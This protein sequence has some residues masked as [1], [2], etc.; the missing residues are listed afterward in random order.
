MIPFDEYSFSIVPVNDETKRISRMRLIP[1]NGS[2]TVEYVST[3]TSVFVTPQVGALKIIRDVI[4][5]IDENEQRLTIPEEVVYEIN[6]FNYLDYQHRDGVLVTVPEVDETGQHTQDEHVVVFSIMNQVDTEKMPISIKLDKIKW[7]S[8]PES[9]QHV[10]VEI[11]KYINTAPSGEP[12]IMEWVPF[13]QEDQ[14]IAD[15]DGTLNQPIIM[16]DVGEDIKYKAIVYHYELEEEHVFYFYS[17]KKPICGENPIVDKVEWEGRKLYIACPNVQFSAEGDLNLADW[18]FPMDFQTKGINLRSSIIS[19][20]ADSYNFKCLVDGSNRALPCVASY[21]DRVYNFP[22]DQEFDNILANDI[23]TPASGN[24]RIIAFNFLIKS[25]EV[26]DRCEF[27]KYKDINNVDRFIGIER[28]SVNSEYYLSIG[29]QSYLWSLCTN[30]DLLNKWNTIF[31]CFLNKNN[32]NYCRALIPNLTN[33]F[34]QGLKRGDNLQYIPKENSQYFN[35]DK[36]DF[37]VT[38]EYTGNSTNNIKAYLLVYLFQ[39]HDRYPYGR[40]E[41]IELILDGRSYV[42]TTI[43]NEFAYAARFGF[44]IVVN[45]DL[46]QDTILIDDV[47]IN[48]NVLTLIDNDYDTEFSD[49]R[50]ANYISFTWSRI[51]TRQV[52]VL[53]NVLNGFSGNFTVNTEIKASAVPMYFGGGGGDFAISHFSCKNAIVNSGFVI[54]DVDADLFAYFG[55]KLVKTMILGYEL[56]PRLM[57]SNEDLETCII[58]GNYIEELKGEQVVFFVE[59]INNTLLENKESDELQVSV[60][61][62]SKLDY[63]TQQVLTT[64]TRLFKNIKE[65]S[66]VPYDIDFETDFDTAVAQFKQHYYAKQKRWGGDM[67]GGVNAELVYFDRGRKCLVLEQHGDYYEGDV[68]AIAP[69]GA[70]G[71]GFPVSLKENPETWEDSKRFAQRNIRVAGLIQSINYHGYGMFDCWFKVPKGMTGLAICLW[72]FHY[73]EIYNYDRYWDF[74][75]NE[76]FRHAD[77]NLYKYDE[78][79]ASGFGATWFVV[80]NEIDMELGSENT[81]YRCATNPNNDSAFK[82]FAPGLSMRQSIGVDTEGNDYGLWMI[83]WER[84]K[85]TIQQTIETY[86]VDPTDE[87]CWIPSSQLVWVKV[88]DNFDAVNSGATVRSCRFNNWLN[89]RWN[90]GCGASNVQQS[91]IYKRSEMDVNNRTPLGE[92]RHNTLGELIGYIEHYYDDEQYHKWSIDWQPTRTRLLIDDEEIAICDAFVPFNPMTMLVGCWFP[93]ANVYD[94]GP[95]AGNYGTWAGI[96]ANFDVANMLVKR[97]KFTPYS[98]QEASTEHMRYDCETYAQDGLRELVY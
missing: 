31:I 74:W 35:V 79:V 93:S 87:R 1:V 71:Y 9:A 44:K 95:R 77:G 48:N 90:D 69:A 59:G 83:D 49:V 98:E 18:G 88:K 3:D 8:T 33:P 43:Q 5:L 62:K 75:V 80:N 14:Y 64:F 68:P 28:S 65:L 39:Y 13:I 23:L 42:T 47:K 57:I 56:T 20:D 4:T 22:N 12:P 16:T 67:G 52:S 54:E 66:R 7:S 2:D 21:P 91:G 81:P 38:V 94:A 53:T 30:N 85:T 15:T 72:Y 46:V 84:S 92:L 86:G 55:E 19:S 37:D 50:L 51:E 96:H 61:T 11:Q 29:G 89:E 40:L 17:P 60:I 24:L 45:N 63:S 76:G 41:E 82:W 32:T 70:I 27:L 34:A 6:D 58:G 10:T 26:G 25:I 78:S 73:Q 97:I 36:Q